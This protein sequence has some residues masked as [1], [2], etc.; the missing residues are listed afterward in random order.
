[1]ARFLLEMPLMRTIM[2]NKILLAAAITVASMQTNAVPFAPTDAR[3]MAMGGTGVASAK[4]VRATQFNPSLL[5]LA[6]DRDDFGL[7]LP[8]VGIYV[9]DENEFID[10]ADE[11][12]EKDYA[13]L[14]ENSVNDIELAVSSATVSFPAVDKAI[15]SEDLTALQPA[16]TTLAGDVNALTRG[17]FNLQAATSDLNNGLRTLS[18]KAVRGG[19]GI[20]A[21]VAVPSKHFSVALSV[22]ST[23]TFSG[24]LRVAESDLATLSNYTNAANAY[25]NALNEFSTASSAATDTLV[26]LDAEINGASNSTRLAALR[27]QLNNDRVALTANKDALEAFNYGGD[28]TVAE[29]GDTVIFQNGELAPGTDNITLQ[30]EAQI[31]AV[32]VSE[33]AMSVSREF[34]IANQAIAIGVTPKMQRIDVYDYIA[35]VKDSVETDD[36]TDS[37]IDDMGFN[38]DI[39]ASMHFGNLDQG[40]V[41]LV[42]K[43]LINREITSVRGKVVK[44]TPQLRAGIAYSF[45]EWLNL[46]ADIDLIE[47]EP[48]A[49]EDPTQYVALGAE[50]DL[51]GIM[52]TRLGYR[53]N[54]ASNDQNIVSGGFGLSPFGVHV[55]LGFYANTSNP[56]RE[57]GVVLETGI[58][59]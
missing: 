49:F 9:S 23:T 24:L 45:G 56:E 54:L 48:V 15:E 27:A 14:F 26:D 38:M 18:D 8:Q 7:L 32:A 4:T 20:A 52:Q 16:N 28:S 37:G 35:N 51:L 59:W 22:N 11:F 3:A 13:T 58:D 5:S 33:V 39:G 25:A 30:S 55:D 6:N 36:I 43:N 41:G 2:N 40:I 21:G 57:A 44:I 19:V 46:A 17:T 53:S 50:F 10:S 47:N 1:V 31:I 12:V 34:E 29:D 42:A